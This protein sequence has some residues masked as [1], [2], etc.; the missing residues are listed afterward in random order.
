MAGLDQW[1]VGVLNCLDGTATS[2]LIRPRGR[3]VLS[4]GLRRFREGEGLLGDAVPR[5]FADGARVALR[6]VS[7][8]PLGRGLERLATPGSATSCLQSTTSRCRPQQALSSTSSS[9]TRGVFPRR[10]VSPF[11][12]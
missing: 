12:T 8:E 7:A 5:P 2:P 11:T 9:V 3:Y 4:T 10:A 6:T 1:N